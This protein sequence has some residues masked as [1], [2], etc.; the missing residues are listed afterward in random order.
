MN[1]TD[2][3]WIEKLVVANLLHP[4]DR[5]ETKKMFVEHWNALPA[6]CRITTTRFGR[7][8]RLAKIRG[9]WWRV[10]VVS[11]RKAFA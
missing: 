7:S 9:Q 2:L 5:S 3:P 8:Q 4:S 10:E 11:E 6:D 1:I